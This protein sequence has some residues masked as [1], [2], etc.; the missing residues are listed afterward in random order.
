MNLTSYEQL[1][2]LRPP[3][4]L[5]EF[6]LNDNILSLSD[7]TDHRNE[8]SPLNAENLGIA[9]LYTSQTNKGHKTTF[10]S[11]PW[12]PFQSSGNF[13]PFDQGFIQTD[14]ERSAVRAAS[15]KQA[16]Q[17]EPVI[18]IR[19]ASEILEA[20][21]LLMRPSLLKKSFFKNWDHAPLFWIKA[22]SYKCKVEILIPA[23][24]VFKNIEHSRFSI[25]LFPWSTPTYFGVGANYSSAMAE[26]GQHYK[27]SRSKNPTD[28][29]FVNLSRF[30]AT[31][32][33]VLLIP[34]PF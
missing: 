13:K 16:L 11:L 21:H 12:R 22:L 3:N 31:N 19:G 25:E 6:F 28:I 8:A 7:K 4:D 14:S 2:G 17:I 34:S 18:F 20:Q 24:I 26:A 1:G 23:D 9:G 29:F 27:N 5:L 10:A 15:I 33:V 30:G 32:K